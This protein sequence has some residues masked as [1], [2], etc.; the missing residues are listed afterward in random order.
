MGAQLVLEKVGIHFPH[1]VLFEQVNWTLYEGMRVTLAGRNG[2]GKSTILRILAGKMEPHDGMRTVVGGRRLRIGYLDQQLLDDA[3]LEVD[4]LKDKSLSSIDYL[5]KHLLQQ[6]GEIDEAAADWEIEKVMAGLGFT[7]EML[8]DS[9]DHLSGG[10]LLRLFI[11]ATILNRP[12][13]LLLDEPTNHL[14]MSSIQWL[15]DYLAKD[16]QG[17]LIMITHDVSLQKRTTDSL[18][19][20]HGGRFYFRKYQSDYLSFLES[21]EEEKRHLEKNIESLEKKIKD[22]MEFV[23]TFRAKARMASRAQSKI[24]AVDK[25]EE[26][27]EILKDRLARVQGFSYKLHFHF[28]MDSAGARFPISTENLSFKYSEKGPLILKDLNFDIR[29]GQKIAIIGDNGAGKTTLLNVLAERLKPT[30]GKLSV[31]Y[32]VDS[33]YF[34]QHQLDELSMD[35]TVLENLRE[36]AVNVSLQQLRGIRCFSLGDVFLP[37][38]ILE[39]SNNRSD[40]F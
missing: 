32:N 33:G 19:I 12:D 13:V 1:R 27:L 39:S 6:G 4:K 22:H 28:R 40:T 17:S 5:K 2:S 14:D 31:G 36:K 34:G 21:L 7:P 37:Q 38:E 11:G 3:V 16:F 29:R 25:L 9:L 26:E 8:G 10:W 20:L 15:E 24:K 30:E 18:A 35:G 23:R